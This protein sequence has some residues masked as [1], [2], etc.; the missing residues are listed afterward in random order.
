MKPLRSLA[1]HRILG[2]SLPLGLSSPEARSE[3]RGEKQF[4]H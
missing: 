1:E 3:G 4:S 2:T